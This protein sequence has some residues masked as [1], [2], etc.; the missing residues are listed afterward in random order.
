MLCDTLLRLAEY[1]LYL[2]RWSRQTTIELERATPQTAQK[3]TQ[4]IL[5]H[6]GDA[7]VE[8][9]EAVISAMVYDEKD[10]RVVAAAV[11]AGAEVIVTLN[12]KDSTGR[13][14]AFWSG[15][16]NIPTDFLRGR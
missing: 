10:R 6:F 4:A 3:R 12:L 7:L 15:G 1:R 9:S 2:L 5:D 8:G 14:A 16:P 13:L 11:R